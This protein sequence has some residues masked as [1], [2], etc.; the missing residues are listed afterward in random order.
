[1]LTLED[2]VGKNKTVINELN[3]ALKLKDE[4]LG[5]KAEELSTLKVKASGEVIFSTD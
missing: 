3:A 1:M 5:A 4:T 2:T